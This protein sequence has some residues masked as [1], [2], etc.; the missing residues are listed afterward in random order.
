MPRDPA[1]ERFEW[2]RSHSL[3]QSI[4]PWIYHHG[5]GTKPEDWFDECRS[6]WDLTLTMP[7]VREGES[8][9]A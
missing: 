2:A 3:G 5:P 7:L 9:G 8:S 4:G 1:A 6:A